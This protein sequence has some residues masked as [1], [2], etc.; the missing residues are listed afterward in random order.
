MRLLFT[1]CTISLFSLGAGTSQAATL[2]YNFPTATVLGGTG[3]NEIRATFLEVLKPVNLE[4]LTVELALDQTRDIDATWTIYNSNA[5]DDVGSVVKSVDADFSF[6]ADNR[7][8]EL[9][10]TDIDVMLGAGFYLFAMQTD[11]SLFY[12]HYI[13]GTLPAGTLPF[14]TTDG[15]F[16]VINGGIL[17]F[18]ASDPS[19]IRGNTSLP[20]ISAEYEIVTTVPAVPL[21]ASGLM[22]LSALGAGLIARKKHGR[23]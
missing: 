8:Q 21:P 7:E 13:E 10:T 17:N 22:L 3:V 19:I 4:S 6:T 18:A 1:A 5:N 11:A 23:T 2:E 20:A 16:S 14:T 12:T 15:A 9:I